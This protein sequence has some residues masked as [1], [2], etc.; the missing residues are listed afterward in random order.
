MIYT[1]HFTGAELRF[2][3]NRGRALITAPSPEAA[4]ARLRE[5]FRPVREEEVRSRGEHLFKIRF[6][7]ALGYRP[8]LLRSVQRAVK[9][10]RTTELYKR[11]RFIDR[12]AVASICRE[13]GKPTWLAETNLIEEIRALRKAAVVAREVSNVMRFVDWDIAIH[14]HIEINSK[15]GHHSRVIRQV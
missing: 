11:G 8:S 3:G 1:F 7:V 13:T 2:A 10:L 6:R 9:L 5:L 4:L 14:N 15:T 12:Y